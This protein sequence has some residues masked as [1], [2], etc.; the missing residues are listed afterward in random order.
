M[1]VGG[2]MRRHQ[3]QSIQHSMQHSVLCLFQVGLT[4]PV[5]R[6]YSQLAAGQERH[7]KGS[8]TSSLREMKSDPLPRTSRDAGPYLKRQSRQLGQHAV[9]PLPYFQIHSSAEGSV[10]AT[11]LP[12]TWPALRQKTYW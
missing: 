12:S 3:V 9:L 10:A 5:G 2:L 7:G 1:A 8:D 4:V 11:A 6:V